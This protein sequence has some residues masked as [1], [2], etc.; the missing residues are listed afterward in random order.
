MTTIWD[1]PPHEELLYLIKRPLCLLYGPLIA[2]SISRTLE[3]HP[4]E[5]LP[6]VLALS[7]AAIPPWRPY[8]C[9]PG[10]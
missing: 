4:E 3:V 5:R 10:I 8:T 7:G 9:D 6:R 2:A 1:R